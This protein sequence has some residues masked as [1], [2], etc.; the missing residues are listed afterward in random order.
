M[1]TPFIVLVFTLYSL[2]FLYTLVGMEIYG[3]KINS[4]IF[5]SIFELNPDSDIGGDYVWLNFN[6]YPSGL[7][8]LFSMMLFNNW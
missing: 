6:D 8:T 3:G 1:R 2:Y 7:L 5:E 4:K